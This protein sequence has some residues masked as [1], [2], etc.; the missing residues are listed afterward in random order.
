MCRELRIPLVVHFHGADAY[1]TENLD[2][3]KESYKKMFVYSSAIIS[4]SRHMTEQLVRLGAPNEKVFY[5]SYGVEVCKFKQAS[6]HAFPLRALAVGRF[7]EKK[8]PYLTILAFKK[9]LERLPEAKLEMVG[10]GPLHEVCRQLIQ[11]LHME[12][13]VHLL[14]HP[15]EVSRRI[16]S[17]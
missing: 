8:A 12:H 7:V 3:H 2:R 6:F 16:P 5:N 10:V 14:T 15:H 4:V 1:S 17:H 13:A 11:S 9:V